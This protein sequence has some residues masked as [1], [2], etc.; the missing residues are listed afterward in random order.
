MGIKNEQATVFEEEPV[1]TFVTRITAIDLD[2]TS[3]NNEVHY[4]FWAGSRNKD[5]DSFTIDSK[6]GKVF[7]KEVFDRERKNVYNL[8]VE[9]KDGAGV[10]SKG[11][12]KSIQVQVVDKNDNSPYFERSM[13]E[14]EVDQD[15]NIGHTVLTLTANDKDES[16]RLRYEIT[17][18]NFGGAFSVDKTTGAISVARPLDYES[19]QKFELQLVATDSLN[20][21]Y[22]TVV[23]H[24]YNVND[25][26]PVFD[27]HIYE[28]DISEEDVG[29]LPTK[30]LKV[31]AKDGD[32]DRPENIVYFLEGK[33]SDMSMFD[34]N[35]TTGEISVLKSLDRDELNGRL[36]WKFTVIA[37]DEGGIGL[38]GYADV[39][40]NLI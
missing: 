32:R 28:V 18:G 16:S 11:F 40:V 7:T 13:Y 37:Q 21:N 17:S 5:K 14:A 25:C 27:Q 30:I 10:L 29:N 31:T 38:A 33:G 6:S 20:E 26:P 4:Q 8:D 39:H 9:V 24:I 1:G 12:F 35:R 15:E 19:R 23:I 36:Q 22:T 34:I 2:G 3:P